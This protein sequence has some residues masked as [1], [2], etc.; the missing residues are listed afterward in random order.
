MILFKHQNYKRPSGQ[1]RLKVKMTHTKNRI[2]QNPLVAIVN[3][4]IVDYPTPTNLSYHY[5]FGSLAGVMLVVQIL[6]GIFLAMHYTCL[7]YTSLS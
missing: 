2:V 4:H 1:K 6:T 3:N 7:L 5:G